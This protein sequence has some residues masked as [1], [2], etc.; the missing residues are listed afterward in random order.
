MSESRSHAVVLGAGMAGLLTAG[1]LSASYR[2]VTVVERD[3]LRDSTTRRRGVPQGRHLHHF[4]SRGPQALEELFPGFRHQVAAAGA[5][6]NDVDDLSRVYLRVGNSELNPPGRLGDPAAAMAVYQASRPF[7]ECHLRRRVA[8]SGNVAFLDNHDADEPVLAG[9]RITGI[10]IRDRA[11]AT[12]AALD[13]DLLVDTT[14]RASDT[15]E[16]LRQRGFGDVPQERVASITGYSSQLLR[17]PHGHFAERVAFVNR[18]SAAP[19]ALLVAYEDDTAMLAISRPTCQG[20]PPRDFTEML[21]DVEQLLPPR[22]VAGLRQATT[23]GETSV[24]RSTAAVWRRYDRMP[25][26]PAGLVVLGDALCT[27]NPLYGQGMTVAALQV[28]ALRDC[29]HRSGVDLPG[30]FYR[31]TSRVIAPVWAV[32]RASDQP[33]SVAV[34]RTLRGRMGAWMQ[35]AA[36]RAST[37]DIVVAERIMR[38]RGLVDPP[39]RLKDPA[40]LLRVLAANARLAATGTL[41]I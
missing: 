23:V 27:L 2:A 8:A 1:M 13:C 39:E 11:D 21:V 29:L 40:L 17:I 34:A 22:I 18:G 24:S 26:L 10:R 19:G 30:R 41:G 20:P 7:L 5:V 25:A 6:V 3:I 32:N 33:P 12:T 35:R 16:F 14:G 4:L 9:R 38:V 31:E 15:P 28:L 36:L 37:T